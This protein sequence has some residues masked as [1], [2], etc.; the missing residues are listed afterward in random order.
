LAEHLH[1][2]PSSVTR[3][4]A[5]LTLPD[6]VKNHVSAGTL[7]PSVAYEVGKLADPAQQREVAQ[8][9]V[10]GRLSRDEAVAAVNAKRRM[11]ARR[12]QRQLCTLTYK[13]PR[14]WTVVVT[15]PKQHVTDAEVIDELHHVLDTIRAKTQAP[16]PAA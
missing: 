8:E 10:T 15:A 1:L 11:P 14:N 13:T 3:A 5:L 12:S 4:L 6:E 16:A 2:N 7:A 9:V